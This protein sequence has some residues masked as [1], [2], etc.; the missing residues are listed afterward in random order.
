M[1]NNRVASKQRIKSSYIHFTKTSKA[2]PNMQG[3]RQI[4]LPCPIVTAKQYFA[5]Q[6]HAGLPDP[7]HAKSPCL[8]TVQSLMA[9]NCTQEPVLGRWDWYNSL[10]NGWHASTR[11]RPFCKWKEDN[12]FGRS[13]YSLATVDPQLWG[14]VL[15]DVIQTHDAEFEH[16]IVHRFHQLWVK[17][18]H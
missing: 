18:E 9:G 1:S 3:P 15:Y 7:P 12:R 14:L 5:R 8:S 2:P 16:V 4:H 11:G 10:G 13:C 17:P 6:G